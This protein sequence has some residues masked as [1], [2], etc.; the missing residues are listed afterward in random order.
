MGCRLDRAPK[1]RVAEEWLPAGGD[2]SVALLLLCQ[3]PWRLS[4]RATTG[5]RGDPA[6]AEAE[7]RGRHR[8]MGAVEGGAGNEASFP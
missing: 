5:L 4:G 6:R 3:V 2:Y 8:T 7:G 1:R